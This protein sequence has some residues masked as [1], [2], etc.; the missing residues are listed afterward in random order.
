MYIFLMAEASSR[1]AA[2]GSACFPSS[3]VAL[4][5]PSEDSE[6]V[7]VLPERRAMIP[8]ILEVT[9]AS[10]TSA[11]APGYENDTLMKLPD[12]DGLYCTLSMGR[13]A[14]PITDSTAIINIT[15]NDGIL[16]I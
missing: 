14:M 9:S 7:P 15:E 2:A 6:E 1:R 4:P 16:F 13:E 8:S 5:Y 3:T 10:T 12:S 11:D